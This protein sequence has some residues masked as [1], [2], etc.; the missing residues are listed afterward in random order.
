MKTQITAPDH[1][2]RVNDDAIKSSWCAAPGSMVPW[3]TDMKT[4]DLVLAMRQATKGVRV[5]RSV[6]CKKKK[7]EKGKKWRR[8]KENVRDEEMRE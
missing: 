5:P 6:Q 7:E 1:R 4:S 3:F 8:R 2:K